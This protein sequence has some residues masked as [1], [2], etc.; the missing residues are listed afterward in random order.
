MA[1]VTRI[2]GSKTGVGT[3]Y[4][5]NCNLYLITVMDKDAAA[6]NLQTEDSA[7][8]DAIVYGVVEAIVDEISP[9][10]YFA[11][12]DTSGH[13]YVVMDKAL[14]DAD[15]LKLRIRNLGYVVGVSATSTGAS[16]TVISGTTVTA[17][18]SFTVVA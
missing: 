16:V 15:S 13:I 7:G 14:N 10:A 3:L 11:P 4:N 6:I 12:A 9:L 18:T 17:A 2:N 5:N 8:M 1:T